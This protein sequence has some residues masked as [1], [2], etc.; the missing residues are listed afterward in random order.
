MEDQE[1][2]PSASLRWAEV[3]D[4]DQEKENTMDLPAQAEQVYQGI[5]IFTTITSFLTLLFTAYSASVLWRR[6]R[7]WRQTAARTPATG[8][9]EENFAANQTTRTSNPYALSVNLLRD[10][11]T[12]EPDVRRY[13]SEQGLACPPFAEISLSGIQNP[14]EDL[15]A[16][17]AQVREKR[18]YLDSES[19]T[20]VHLFFAGPIAAGL[21]LGAALD[22]WKL[23]KVFQMSN[24]NGQRQ[25]EYWGV[26]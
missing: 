11:V 13:Y 1:G 14:G 12:C 23:V 24:V 7:A 4:F 22:N 5:D 19:A 25:Y 15:G 16:L 18:I 9:F 2:E 21:H 8:T 20:E 10:Q 6:K 26:L 3:W 17:V